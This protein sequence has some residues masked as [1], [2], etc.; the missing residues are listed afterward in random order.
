MYLFLLSVNLSYSA[1]VLCSIIQKASNALEVLKEVLDAID[2]K[3][4]QVSQGSV[5]MKLEF[6][7]P[8][9]WFAFYLDSCLVILLHSNK[10]LGLKFGLL[11]VL[12]WQQ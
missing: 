12:N 9:I 5:I 3:H 1:I 6:H 8:R 4:P 2:A 10:V 11:L 7:I